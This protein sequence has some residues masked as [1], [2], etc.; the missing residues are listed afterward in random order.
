MTTAVYQ[1]LTV[2]L[3]VDERGQPLCLVQ[4]GERFNNKAFDINL[5]VAAEEV[6]VI[7]KR[8]WINRVGRNETA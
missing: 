1:F 5:L 4:P 2:A 6:A 8:E 7:A 3:C